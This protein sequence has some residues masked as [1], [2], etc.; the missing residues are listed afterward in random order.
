VQTFA[1][2]DHESS[3]SILAFADGG[4]SC[5]VLALKVK[6]ETIKLSGLRVL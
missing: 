3:Y 6:V 2:Y 1:K 5:I 4:N